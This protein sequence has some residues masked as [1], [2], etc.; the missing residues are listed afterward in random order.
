MKFSYKSTITI[1]SISLLVSACGRT[2]SNEAA[3]HQE[4][5]KNGDLQE[6]TA[7]ANILPTF[8][9]NQH[10]QMRLIYAGAGKA[11]DLLKWIPC[12]CGCGDSAGHSSSVNCFVK[13]VRPDGSIVWDDHGTRCNV[14][15]EIAAKSI[16]L[17]QEGHSLQEIREVIDQTY[18]Q[19]F[20][21]PTDT[22]MPS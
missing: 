22:P 12:Y 6:I 11:T 21:K 10:E 14:C 8:L 9:D 7:S 16:S 3:H 15:L 4:H 1:L 17:A 19:G 13:E 2:N 20:G 5:A 18:N